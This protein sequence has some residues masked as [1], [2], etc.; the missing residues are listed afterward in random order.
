MCDGRFSVSSP[1][2]RFRHPGR[3]PFPGT[4]AAS[5]DPAAVAISAEPEIAPASNPVSGA[6]GAL[7]L[8][9][10]HLPGVSPCDGL[11]GALPGASAPFLSAR[12][13]RLGET[14][15]IHQSENRKRFLF[16]THWTFCASRVRNAY[17]R[18]SS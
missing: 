10:F 9:R 11:F 3:P 4:P 8:A 6:L 13:R 16:G 2:R 17:W 12:L 1:F 18:A 7:G 5:S 14:T 15:L